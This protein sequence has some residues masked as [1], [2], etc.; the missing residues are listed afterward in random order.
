MAT[1]SHLGFPKHGV[2]FSI[3]LLP[4]RPKK[5]EGKA[6]PLLLVDKLIRGTSNYVLSIKMDF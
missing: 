3:L 2:P 6:L 4:S 1:A 5:P